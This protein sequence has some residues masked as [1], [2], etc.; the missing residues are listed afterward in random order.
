MTDLTISA[1]SIGNTCSISFLV[2]SASVQPIS[3][4]KMSFFVFL[5]DS[6]I[7]QVSC[8]WKQ[9]HLGIDC[10]KYSGKCVCGDKHIGK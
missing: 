4:G 1:L 2:V 5:I 7:A 9:S 8:R 3:F 10:M 6:N